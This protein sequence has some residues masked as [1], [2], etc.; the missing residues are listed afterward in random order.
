MDANPT[1]R[2]VALITGASGGIGLEFAR[3]AAAAGHDLV[4]AARSGAR[5]D[6]VAAEL[7]GQHGVTVRTVVADLADP[8]A[9]K[10]VAAAVDGQLP[11]VLINNAGVGGQGRFAV[12]RP[13]GNDLAMIRLNVLSLVEL[14]GLLLPAM[15]ARGSGG[16]LNVA[17]TAG[18][19]P[20]PRQAVYYA[21]KA[22][23]KS[24]SEALTE[25]CR[26]TGVRV[27][28]LCPGPVDTGFARASGLSESMLMKAPGKVPA[29]DVARVGWEALAAGRAVVVPG[30]MARVAMQSLRIAPR[31]LAAGLAGRVNR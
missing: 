6:E 10:S 7:G 24:F 18:Y 9:A 30:L 17:S 8:D 13:L 27:T 5:L 20:G 14:T 15:V 4:L 23:V 19:L 28:A 2:P 16:I 29:A 11:E 26:G 12:E 22:F 1:T 25:E 3:L 21:S 31:R